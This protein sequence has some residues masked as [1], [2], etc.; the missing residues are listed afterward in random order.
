[1]PLINILR[2]T[3][4]LGLGRLTGAIVMI[5]IVALLQI[6][7]IYPETKNTYIVTSS[8]KSRLMKHGGL[9]LKNNLTLKRV[10]DAAFTDADR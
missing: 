7:K 6:T 2:A 8:L 9:K 5:G 10:I 1:M 4:R 3:V